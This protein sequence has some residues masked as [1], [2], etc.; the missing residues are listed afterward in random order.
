[1][2][3]LVLESIRDSDSPLRSTI[4]P[5]L[6]DVGL[7]V[8][9]VA[10]W[11]R[12]SFRGKPGAAF[13]DPASS[14]PLCAMRQVNTH[15][16]HS[17][18]SISQQHVPP[19]STSYIGVR[20][21]LHR[22]A[23]L[24]IAH[25]H[26][27][28]GGLLDARRSISSSLPPRIQTTLFRQ[29]SAKR[30]TLSRQL[31]RP[32]PNP[33]IKACPDPPREHIRIRDTSTLPQ[34]PRSLPM[35][36]FHQDQHAFA[37]RLAQDTALTS[38]RSKSWVMK[39]SKDED[40]VKLPN[41][42]VLYTSPTRTSLQISTPNKA[43]PFTRSSDSGIAY[44]TNQRSFSSPILNLQDTFVRAPFFGPNYWVAL[45]TPV[46]EG[47]IPPVHHSVE[48]RMT[49]REGGAYDFQNTFEQIKERLHE[50]Y[51]VA[52]ENGQR[53][54]DVDL[55]NVG[56][57]QLPAYEQPKSNPVPAAAGAAGSSV[58]AEPPPDYEEVQAQ[59][60]S[61]SLEQRSREEAER[62]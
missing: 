41:E 29:A 20:R 15:Y 6:A 1:M 62:Q 58:P 34:P 21:Q 23:Y 59:A 54:A 26:T 36:Q 49:F 7:A 11:I 13:E 14:E 37:L 22:P 2:R 48:L 57:E 16:A 10:K 19:V 46:P 12:A 35:Y 42:R 17:S 51:M 3:V 45:C 28:T 33:R 9:G 31:I 5:H 47:G 56:L 43:Q 27:H 24:T 60:V 61:A 38:A 8:S 53:Q 32:T 4:G 18:Q 39:S 25:N 40:F 55:E 50:T 30:T 44:I 52:V